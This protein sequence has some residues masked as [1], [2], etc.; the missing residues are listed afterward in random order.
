MHH[1]AL[2]EVRFRRYF[3]ASIFSSLGSWMLRF[4]FGWSAWELTHSA[5]WVGVVAGLMLAPALVLSPVFGILADRV[6]PRFGLIISMVFHA[7][8]ALIGGLAMIYGL[9]SLTTLLILAL[10][11]GVGLS[12]HTPM[13]LALIP[14]L[15]GRDALPSAVGL[16][17]MTFNSARIVGPAIGAWVLSISGSAEAYLLAALMF[18][19]SLLI[20]STLSGI[21]GREPKPREPFLQQFRA[22]L[23]YVYTHPGL[24]LIFAFTVVNGLL[25]RTVIELLPA[26]SGQ[27]IAGDSGDLAVLTAF[28]GA[29]S[30]V[31]GLIVSRQR[32]Q[33]K[34]LLLLI[35]VALIIGAL[36]L[37]GLRLAASLWGLCVAVSILALTTTMCGTGAQTLT[38]LSVEEDYRGRV[39][40]LWAVVAMV[41]PAAGTFV[42]GALA[43]WLGFIG[44]LTITGGLGV[45]LVSLLYARRRELLDESPSAS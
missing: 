19:V 14:L 2:A 42:I 13:R 6:N 4:L 27:L 22:G 25:G 16:S 20:L 38:H 9:Y 37:V 15:V 35:A 36:V 3:P 28:A 10:A 23:A 21:G 31:G 43:D 45:L 5:A 33:L 26:V 11:M 18:T 32:A 34:R 41:A 30:I 17:A 12:G 7:T 8:I 29:G 24:R 39:L 1:S 40:S 44:V